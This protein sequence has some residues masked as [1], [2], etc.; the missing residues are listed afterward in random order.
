[1]QIY[2]EIL[3][4]GQIDCWRIQC[5][6]ITMATGTSSGC[7]DYSAAPAAATSFA[8]CCAPRCDPNGGASHSA[9]P[10]AIAVTVT[11][12]CLR[13]VDGRRADGG[14]R[15]D[16]EDDDGGGGRDDGDDEN[17][18]NNGTAAGTAGRPCFNEGRVYQSGA[19][20]DDPVDMCTS[21]DCKVRTG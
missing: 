10:T 18:D 4:L 2:D 15:D 5:P 21:C 9:M 11:D 12:P 17:N 16:D 19:H 7:A 1:M 14:G 6:P 3:Q 13:H 8:D 20:W